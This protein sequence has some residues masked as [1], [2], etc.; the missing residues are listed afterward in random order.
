MDR[1]QALRA[2][3]RATNLAGK[4]AKE[5]H[6]KLVEIFKPLAGKK[7]CTIDGGLTK[8]VR[9]KLPPR[10]SVADT[11]FLG[12]FMDADWKFYQGIH[13]RTYS[14]TPRPLTFTVKACVRERG[15]MGCSYAEA[16]VYVCD[17]KDGRVKS[18]GQWYDPPSHKTDYTPEAVTAAREACQRKERE[19]QDARS[20]LGSFGMSDF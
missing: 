20:A 11:D 8:R 4:S 10:N 14:D 6:A 13:F 12:E 5:L 18:D 17:I 1:A 9:D 7:V 15:V 16:L 3:V 19:A 2:K